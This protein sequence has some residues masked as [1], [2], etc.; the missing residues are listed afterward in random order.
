MNGPDRPSCYLLLNVTLLPAV[1]QLE[2]LREK[3]IS[4]PG[5]AEEHIRQIERH[6]PALNAFAELSGPSAPVRY[7]DAMRCWRLRWNASLGKRSLR[8]AGDRESRTFQRRN[9]TLH[10]LKGWVWLKGVRYSA[11]GPEAAAS[12]FG[13]TRSR[14]SLLGLK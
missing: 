5:L 8:C 14:N 1:E 13:F 4:A 12:S 2:L 11:D 3:K 10:L 6:N 7:L 9:P